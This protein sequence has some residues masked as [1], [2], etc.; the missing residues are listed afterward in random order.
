MA[1]KEWLKKYEEKKELLRCKINLESYFTEKQ[2]GKADIDTLE[3]GTVTFPTGTIL[4]CDP[5]I[6][7]ED[8]LPYMQNVPS[9]TYP[10]TI[11]VL[12]SEDFGNRYACVKVAI[13]DN[14][15]VYY[16]LG[17]VGNEDLGEELEEGEYFGFIVDAG[18]GSI[19]DVKTQAAFKTYWEQRCSKEEDIAP[20]N[21]LFCELLEENSEKIQSISVKEGTGLTGLFQKQSL[22]FLFSH[23]DGEMGI[24]PTYFGYDFEGKVC[25]IYI[26][27]I[28]I[29]KEKE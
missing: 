15:P 22:I 21:A 27:F 25:G 9:G 14:K 26:L 16:D 7:L 1:D 3:I 19:L 29:E 10:V 17:V 4:A 24:Y 13:T 23:L 12:L 8:A 20:Y 18:M 5:L 2:I 11:C 6:E 28:D